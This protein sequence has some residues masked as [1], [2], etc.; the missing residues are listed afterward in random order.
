MMKDTITV[1]NN[2]IIILN[3]TVCIFSSEV[4]RASPPLKHLP[5]YKAIIP[6]SGEVKNIVGA[7]KIPEEKGMKS[8]SAEYAF[9]CLKK[10]TNLFK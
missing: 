10:E 6:P 5:T 8:I 3:M 7:D 2:I 9:D 1:S 4:A